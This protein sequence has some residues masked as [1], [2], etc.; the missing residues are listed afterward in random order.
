[1]NDNNTVDVSVVAPIYNEEEVIEEVVLYWF[2]VLEKYGLSYEVV[3]GDGGS[4]DRTLDILKEIQQKHP[5]LKVVDAPRPSGYGNALFTAIYAAKGKYI[6]M[7]DSDGQFDL[8]DFTPMLDKL[9]E[10]KLDVV[11][12]YRIRK[13]DTFMRY[14]AD[15]VLNVIVRILFKIKQ[16]DTNCALKVFKGDLI[17]DIHIEARAW[18]TPTE[19]MLRLNARD[20]KVGEVPIVHHE[21]KGGETKLP[22]FKTGFEMFCFLL[23]FKFKLRLYKKNVI[24]K[25]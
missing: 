22:L 15:R 18:P 11:T 20:S 25:L 5:S 19:V 12:G 23:Y 21:R 17:R 3:L 1:M 24:S 10:E 6:V 9:V 2:E 13:Q 14:F 8:A 4:T 16:K 7:L